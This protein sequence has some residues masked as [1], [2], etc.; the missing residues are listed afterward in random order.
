MKPRGCTGNGCLFCR[1]GQADWSAQVLANRQTR[2]FTKGSIL[3]AEGE[4]VTGVFFMY[5]GLVKIHKQWAPQKQLIVHFAQ[6]GEMIGYR[7][8]GDDPIF[9]VTATALE[10]TII[11]WFELPFFEVS[12][13]LNHGLTL[14]LMKVFANALQ[15]AEKRMRNLALMVVKAR[16]ADM[17][18]MLQ[19]TFGTGVNGYINGRQTR[20]DM[21][22]YAGIPY[23]TLFRTFQELERQGLIQ[24]TGKQLRLLDPDA[25][26]QLTQLTTND[27]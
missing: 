22:A 4:P 12:L 6:P 8:L 24:Q 21:A 27:Q 10:E 18:L 7:G 23:E 25:L 17:L 26:R 20:Q 13:T 2:R 9:P 11:C 19:R 14:T 15:E 1:A 5:S 16:V 3:F